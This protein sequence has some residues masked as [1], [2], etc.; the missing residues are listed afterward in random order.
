MVRFHIKQNDTSPAIKHQ[1]LD[2]E[3]SPIDL[4]GASV[5]FHMVDSDGSVKVNTSASIDNAGNGEVSY[6]WSAGDT[7]TEGVYK[8]EWE[9]DFGNG[10]IESFPNSSDFIVDIENELA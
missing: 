2:E 9:V 7:D 1:L 10:S 6:S 8:A 4:T 3:G 5:S